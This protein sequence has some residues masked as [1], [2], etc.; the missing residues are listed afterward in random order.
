M[1]KHTPTEHQKPFVRR[2]C[3]ECEFFVPQSVEQGCCHESPA[4]VLKRPTDWCGQFQSKPLKE[5][6]NA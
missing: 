3:G 4:A 1:S 5:K 6:I 2:A